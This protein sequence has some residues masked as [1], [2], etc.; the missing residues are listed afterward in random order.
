MLALACTLTAC[1][2]T[3][4]ISRVSGPPVEADIVGGTPSRIIVEDE[5][6]TRVAIPRSDI[7]DIDHPGNVHAVVGS[8]ILAYGLLNIAVGLPE[9]RSRDV[10]QV[11]FCT[12]LFAPAVVGAGMIVWGLL[13]HSASVD[14]TMDTS[15]PEPFPAN[16]G[17]GP[18]LAPPSPAPFGVPPAP[19]FAPPAAPPS[20]TDAVTAPPAP[21]GPPPPV[22]PAPV[23]PPSPPVPPQPAGD[24]AAPK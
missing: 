1:S 10:E 5:S 18:P 22:P 24:P 11:P 4:T 19:L 6:G 21:P 23:A 8:G 7:R 14:S 17:W 2:T 15:M 9:C 3:A 12:G 13:T 16:G 20:G